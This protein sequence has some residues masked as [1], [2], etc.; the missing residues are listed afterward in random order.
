MSAPQIIVTFIPSEEVLLPV[1]VQNLAVILQQ[2][3]AGEK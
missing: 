3:A 1:E 2:Q